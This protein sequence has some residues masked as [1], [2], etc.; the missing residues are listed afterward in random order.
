[1]IT[2]L[3]QHCSAMITPLLQ[4]CS[5]NNTVTTCAIFICVDHFHNGRHYEEKVVLNCADTRTRRER[6]IEMNIILFILNKFPKIRL[7][8]D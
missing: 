3:L 8:Y 5:T 6:L 7:I 2:M 1:M 4:H